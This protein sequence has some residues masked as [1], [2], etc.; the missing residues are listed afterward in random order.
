LFVDRWTDLIVLQ[1]LIKPRVLIGVG[2]LGAAM[3]VASVLIGSVRNAQASDAFRST[4][5][6]YSA[7]PTEP[8]QSGSSASI[9][10]LGATLTA[11]S[12]EANC[13]LDADYEEDVT[14]PDNT[15]LEPGERF[16]KTWRI[17]NTGTC[18]WT[19]A[20]RLQFMGGAQMDGSDAV[21]VPE[22]SPGESVEVSVELVAPSS[23]GAYRGDWQI[24]SGSGEPFGSL[25][26]V[27]IIVTDPSD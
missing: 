8:S 3:I 2:A 26:Y 19:S 5:A 15:F 14:V 7:L 20:Y 22:A 13:E 17:L 4:G 24:H 1:K 11:V 10:S 18:T 9:R 23:R 21:G 27:Q 25:L 6:A 12:L 16:V